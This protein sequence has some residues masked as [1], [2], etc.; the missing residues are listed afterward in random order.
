VSGR[1]FNCWSGMKSGCVALR[2]NEAFAPCPAS[3]Q[4]AQE[5][6]MLACGVWALRG[7]TKGPRSGATIDRN[8]TGL[9]LLSLSE[10]VVIFNQIRC[11][12][13]PA[14]A[15]RWNSWLSGKANTLS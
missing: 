5:P 8:F 13:T 4:R 2:P 1:R 9:I 12:H 14:L 3:S 7:A 15:L 6:A 11:T 10:L